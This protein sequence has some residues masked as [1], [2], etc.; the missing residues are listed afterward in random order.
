MSDKPKTLKDDPIF[1]ENPT[2]DFVG[3]PMK[4]REWNKSWSNC[5]S[6]AHDNPGHWDSDNG[7]KSGT[8]C[9]LCYRWNAFEEIEA[10]NERLKEELTEAERQ[11]SNG[12]EF[13][14]ETAEERDALKAEQARWR[15]TDAWALIEERD[16]IKAKLAALDRDHADDWKRIQDAER[17]LAEVEAERDECVKVHDENINLM[18][19]FQ[20]LMSQC[21]NEL[22]REREAA[23]VMREALIRYRKVSVPS[24]SDGTLNTRD[25][26]YVAEE[27]LAKADEIRGG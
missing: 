21:A 9:E 14:N 17:K 3:R 20:K 5:E 4:P 22:E 12:V 11:Y 7:D 8:V 13:L 24:Y 6:H 2:H 27:A 18:R 15:E 23:K 1:G 19:E 10:E 26:I 25:R 16:T